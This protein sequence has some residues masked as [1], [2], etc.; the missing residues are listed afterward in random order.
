MASAVVQGGGTG[1]CGGTLQL[2]TDPSAAGYCSD[3]RLQTDFK[4]GDPSPERQSFAEAPQQDNQSGGCGGGSAAFDES[5]VKREL[6]KVRQS[7]EEGGE[8]SRTDFQTKLPGNCLGSVSSGAADNGPLLQCIS[9]DTPHSH[10]DSGVSCSVGNNA[11]SGTAAVSC[12]DTRV[13]VPDARVTHIDKDPGESNAGVL[14]RTSPQAT[15]TAWGN[16]E[17]HSAGPHIPQTGGTTG[18]GGVEVEGPS[19]IAPP[20]S[21][22]DSPSR[23]LRERLS[24]ASLSGDEFLDNEEY[25]IHLSRRIEQKSSAEHSPHLMYRLVDIDEEYRDGFPDTTA[26]AMPDMAGASIDNPA[27]DTTEVEEDGN[28][29]DSVMTPDQTDHHTEQS[30]Q[31]TADVA[32]QHISS[33]TTAQH[34]ETDTTELEE[35]ISS[36]ITETSHSDGDTAGRS[37]GVARRQVILDND[38]TWE[39]SPSGAGVTLR[40]KTQSS[41]QTPRE[42]RHSGRSWHEL[43]AGI[44]VR[45]GTGNCLH[46]MFSF[47]TTP[48]S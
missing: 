4:T 41:Q 2:P 40:A 23:F 26:P 1:D 15:A 17:S 18:D 16:L 39:S 32:F 31:L 35:G 11:E 47:H 13:R 45:Y 36:A 25:I 5:A 37:N 24:T 27:T 44:R 46:C 6:L 42:Y 28:R 33:P 9:T 12:N 21:P 30:Q 38:S 14:T 48:G 19:L 20:D 29:G 8:D 22:L 34:T 10:G 3:T 43:K 7:F